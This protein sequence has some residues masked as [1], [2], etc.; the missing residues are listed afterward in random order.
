MSSKKHK[1]YIEELKAIAKEI[2]S[3][4]EK[5]A[6]FFKTVGIHTKSGNLTSAYTSPK[7]G[8]K[9]AKDNR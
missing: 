9:T 3:S 2:L 7:V 1:Q 4:K 8:F 6:E 5:S